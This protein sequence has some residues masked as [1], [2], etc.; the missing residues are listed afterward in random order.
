MA[1]PLVVFQTYGSPP[2]AR[3]VALA[4][5]SLVRTLPETAGPVQVVLYT[6]DPEGFA[7]L[8]PP[9]VRARLAI[10]Y[11]V[12]NTATLQAW[13][14]PQDFV[15]RAKVEMIRHCFDHF[16]PGTLLYLDSDILF[17]QDPTPLL[18]E[19][20]E[21]VSLMHIRE[22]SFDA[23]KSPLTR[24]IR[25]R[26]G[27]VRLPLVGGPGTLPAHTPMWNAGVLGLHH[28][29]RPHVDT[30]LAL[31]DA[32][33]SA[34]PKHVMEQL[35]FSYTLNALGKV[36]P[37]SPYMYHYWY[38]KPEIN[39]AAE[40]LL[41]NPAASERFFKEV[42]PVWAARWV[43]PNRRRRWYHRLL[44]LRKPVQVPPALPATQKV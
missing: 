20:A 28:S 34:Y 1:F 14:G 3:Q 21:G 44:G 31:T 17:L 2:I 35:A 27:Q 4:L 26:M 39:A 37:A 11:H 16:S 30:V 6:D 43:G 15:H 29:V 41:S 8:L 36:L 23:P 18:A 19:L 33:Y 12:L 25:R 10:Q 9:P 42:L 24:K 40:A 22:D 7:P 13:R 32:L 38:A 5:T